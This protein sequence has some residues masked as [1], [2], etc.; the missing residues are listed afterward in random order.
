MPMHFAHAAWL[1][2]VEAGDISEVARR[3]SDA[4]RD[5]QGSR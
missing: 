4:E 3:H 2:L 5:P 1:D